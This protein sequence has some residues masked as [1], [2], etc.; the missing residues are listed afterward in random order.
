MPKIIQALEGVLFIAKTNDMGSH[1]YN[2]LLYDLRDAHKK[3]WAYKCQILRAYIQSR[4]W[5][6]LMSKKEENV[7]F[8]TLDYGA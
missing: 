5:D 4:F 1:T 3:I 2:E 7:V 6:D 8:C